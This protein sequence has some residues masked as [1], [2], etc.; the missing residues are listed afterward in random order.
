MVSILD[1]VTH[2]H[3]QILTVKV[4]RT[5]IALTVKQL[6][7]LLYDITGWLNMFVIEIWIVMLTK[8]K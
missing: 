8:L 7:S 5:Q 2:V 4:V 1:K 6:F 3:A